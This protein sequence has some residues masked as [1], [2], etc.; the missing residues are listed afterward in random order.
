MLQYLEAGI[1]SAY[2][3]HSR[4]VCN[5]W[6]QL[7]HLSLGG[8]I[9]QQLCLQFPGNLVLVEVHSMLP[10]LEDKSKRGELFLPK[11]LSWLR[12]SNG[13][14]KYLVQYLYGCAPA[15]PENSMTHVAVAS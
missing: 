7:A 4:M 11:H 14:L 3:L 13:S 15:W 10:G 12:L 6:K 9:T 5:V 2:Q 8:V 1:S